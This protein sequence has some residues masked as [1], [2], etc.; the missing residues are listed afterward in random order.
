MLT[1]SGN[2]PPAMV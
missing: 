2:I 1:S